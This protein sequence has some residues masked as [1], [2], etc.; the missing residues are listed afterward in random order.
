[1]ICN[2]YRILMQIYQAS[3]PCNLQLP[4]ENKKPYLLSITELP[5]AS[6]SHPLTSNFKERKKK[7]Q[8]SRESRPKTYT[9]GS[10]Y[11]RNF[12]LSVP[13][14]LKSDSRPKLVTRKSP[15]AVWPGLAESSADVARTSTLAFTGEIS[16]GWR[17]L[18]VFPASTASVNIFLFHMISF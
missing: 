2:K 3:S 17:R 4:K 14:M 1:M 9:A 7:I 16:T 8:I 5:Q 6:S 18:K 15:C 11:C 12:P 10:I 13:V